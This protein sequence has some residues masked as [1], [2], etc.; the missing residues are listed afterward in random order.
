LRD[1]DSST[2][3]GCAARQLD[4]EARLR[5]M[6]SVEQEVREALERIA[7]IDSVARASNEQTRVDVDYLKSVGILTSQRDK[8]RQLLL[9]TVVD[10]QLTLREAAQKAARLS[11]VAN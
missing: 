6:E 8:F 7:V 11:E 5:Q 10:G 3:L 2:D 1:F 4:A 9:K